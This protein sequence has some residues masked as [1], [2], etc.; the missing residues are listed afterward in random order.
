MIIAACHNRD[1]NKVQTHGV[2]ELREDEQMFPDGK[3][4]VLLLRRQHHAIRSRQRRGRSSGSSGKGGGWGRQLTVRYA[5]CAS[6]GFNLKAFTALMTPGPAAAFCLCRF[7]PKVPRE[8]R[9][10]PLAHKIIIKKNPLCHHM[11]EVKRSLPPY[12]LTDIRRIA[13]RFNKNMATL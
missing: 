1:Q 4:Q 8:H 5:R 10:P 12:E 3:S 9:W 2:V 7:S 13:D 6:V 11:T